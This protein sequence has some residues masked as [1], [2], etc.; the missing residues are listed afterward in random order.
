VTCA[1]SSSISSALVASGEL[2]NH[3]CQSYK[4]ACYLI[5]SHFGKDCLLADLDPDDFAA[6]K[7]KIAKRWGPVTLGNHLQRIHVVFNYAAGDARVVS[8]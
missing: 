5:V 8:C 1:T 6:L 3:S 7:S 4:A 2:S